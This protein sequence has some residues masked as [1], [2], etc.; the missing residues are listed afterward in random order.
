MEAVLG[1]PRVEPEQ[2]AQEEQGAAAQG[3]TAK[4][5]RSGSQ[6]SRMKGSFSPGLEA[7]AGRCGRLNKEELS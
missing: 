3:P 2:E 6:K 4:H 1:E 7:G 5:P